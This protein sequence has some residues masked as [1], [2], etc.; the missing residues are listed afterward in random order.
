MTGQQVYNTIRSNAIA[1]ANKYPKFRNIDI[2][3]W[4]NTGL[5]IAYIESTFNEK[6]KNSHSTAK[7]L[8]QILNGTK[9]EIEKRILSLRKPYATTEKMYDPIYNTLLGMAYLAYQYNRY[10]D[11]DKAIYAYNQGSYPKAGPKKAGL[12]YLNKFKSKYNLAHNGVQ[13]QSEHTLAD[14]KNNFDTEWN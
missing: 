7:G 6:A 9:G 11:W 2:N 3:E 4:I 5:G 14:N 13:K 8:M 10:K 1:L 12:D